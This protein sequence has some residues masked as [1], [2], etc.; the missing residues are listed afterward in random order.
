M[1]KK[2][3]LVWEAD[4][5]YC[6]QARPHHMEISLEDFEY[7]DTEDEVEELLISMLNDDFK[8]R[9]IPVIQG[10]GLDKV[11]KLWKE[12]RAKEAT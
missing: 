12:N 11:L 9:V 1:T 2:I 3:K 6:G 7:C 10:D 8:E 5:G 4:D